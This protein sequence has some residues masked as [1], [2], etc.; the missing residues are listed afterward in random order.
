MDSE[1]AEPIQ[2][3]NEKQSM[4]EQNIPAVRPT[5]N[6]DPDELI[7]V[8]SAAVA[9]SLNRSTHEIIVRSFR[10]I[11]TGS[12]AWNRAAR[13]DLTASKLY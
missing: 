6:E 11:P 1:K 7:A 12:P 3:S 2:P 5:K 4:E 13:Y 9:A 8:I 10:R